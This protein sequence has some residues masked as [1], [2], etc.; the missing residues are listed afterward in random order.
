MTAHPDRG[1][2]I[3]LADGG[4]LAFEVRGAVTLL[5]ALAEPVAHVFGISFGAMVATW[6]AVDAPDRV[7]RLCLASAGPTGLALSASGLHRGLE[8]VAHALVPGDAAAA[9]VQQLTGTAANADAIAAA[10][11]AARNS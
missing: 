2:T 10:V 9:I 4:R 1:G 6:I 7:A 8:M 11:A 3:D 5:D